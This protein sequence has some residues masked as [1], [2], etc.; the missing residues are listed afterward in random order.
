MVKNKKKTFLALGLIVPT[1]AILPITMISCEASE[2][3]KLN[4]ALNKNRKLR[5]ELVAK[6]HGYNGY[7]EF[8]KKINDELT[9]R[10][11]NVTDKAQ[12][13]NIYKDLTARVNAS[14]D[15]LTS[16]RDSIN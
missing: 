5:A 14:N 11:T 6:T 13:I 8:A 3:R 15:D 4:S 16:M 2:R 12:R 7:E 9:S 10:L 1:I